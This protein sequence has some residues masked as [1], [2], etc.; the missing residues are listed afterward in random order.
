MANSTSEGQLIVSGQAMMAQE[1]YPRTYGCPFNISLHKRASRQL[2]IADE[3]PTYQDSSAATSVPPTTLRFSDDKRISGT[4]CQCA[5]CSAL[6][7]M[8]LQCER[9]KAT[10]EA[11]WLDL[12]V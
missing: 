11:N 12:C 9:Q 6:A 8:Q 2:T 10:I 4:D 3:M 7:G 5:F 1:P